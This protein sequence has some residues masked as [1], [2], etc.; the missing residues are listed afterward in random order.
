MT[1]LSG[2]AGTAVVTATSAAVVTDSRYCIAAEKEVYCDWE[3]ICPGSSSNARKWLSDNLQRKDKVG[4]DPFLFTESSWNAYKNHL[5][6][7]EIDLVEDQD[8]IVDKIW[9][10]RPTPS[11]EPLTIQSDEIS[12]ASVNKKI[13]DITDMLETMGRDNLFVTRLGTSS[14]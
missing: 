6:D 7:Y 9:N 12:G 13:S 10:D 2:S 5:D 8:N 11:D 3:I 1:G 4:A 14:K